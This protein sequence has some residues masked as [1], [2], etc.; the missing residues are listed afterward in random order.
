M[1]L[2]EVLTQEISGR[3]NKSMLLRITSENSGVPGPLTGIA[4]PPAAG[5]S[6]WASR[7]HLLP[8]VPHGALATESIDYTVL[9]GKGLGSCQEIPLAS[10]I[11]S[12]KIKPGLTACTGRVQRGSDLGGER[13]SC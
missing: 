9:A 10:Q 13:Y 12:F 6:M 1:A 7:R 4:K 3:S 11:P 8:Q 5:G 2:P